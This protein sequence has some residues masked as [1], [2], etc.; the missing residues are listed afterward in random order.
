ML[1]Q[2][3]ISNCLK[4]LMNY[5]KYLLTKDLKNCVQPAVNN[6]AA[7]SL[8]KTLLITSLLIKTIKLGNVGSGFL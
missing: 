2:Q 4:Y 8:G 6:F 5:Q 7:P 3:D 1:Y